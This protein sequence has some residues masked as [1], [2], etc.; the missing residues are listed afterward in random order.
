MTMSTKTN[1]ILTKQFTDK[2]ALNNELSTLTVQEK[3]QLIDEINT[4]QI[5]GGVFTSG[6]SVASYF[7]S[8]KWKNSNGYKAGTII[9]GL[10]AG[11]GIYSAYLLNEIKNKLKKELG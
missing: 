10:F 8:K 4:S 11:S 5:V 6:W 2:E 1:E 9:T 3:Q 7:L